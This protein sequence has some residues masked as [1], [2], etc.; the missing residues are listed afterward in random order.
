MLNTKRFKNR[1]TE[2][3]ELL[4]TYTSDL[5][6]EDHPARVMSAIVD[7]LDLSPLYSKYSWEGGETYHPKSMLKVLF[8]G[9]SHGTRSSR[10]ISQACRENKDIFKQ[11]VKLC[12]QL[13]MI[14]L[15][16]NVPQRIKLFLL[17]M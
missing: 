1:P 15:M 2:Q 14:S 11:V 17:M 12:Y 5:I 4:P 9:Y 8:Y 13:E 6:D 16:V 3:G 10:K 7:T